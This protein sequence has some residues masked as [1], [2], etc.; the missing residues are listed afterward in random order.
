MSSETV[1]Q[2][3][4][5][6]PR[7]ETFNLNFLETI[8]QLTQS[9]LGNDPLTGQ[10][11]G[12]GVLLPP[13]Y[14]VA[15]TSGLENLGAL[16]TEAGIGS[17]MPY[18]DQANQALVNA[19]GT[20]GSSAIPY[21]EA[22]IG[23][24]LTGQDYTTEAYD[25]AGATRDR[26]Y[27]TI[28]QGLGS[29][30]GTDAMFDPSSIAPFM[31]PYETEVI[32]QMMGD[33]DRARQITGNQIGA[34]AA[35]AGAFGGAR[36]GL[37]EAENNRNA[38]E[39]MARNAANIRQSGYESAAGRAQ[40]AFEN[41]LGRGQ[42][43]GNLQANIGMGIGGLGQADVATLASLGSQY[44]SL[45]QGI[46]GLGQ[47]IGSLGGQLGQLGM[48]FA[49]LGELNTNLNRADID[50]A[51]QVGGL[52]RGVQQAG[53]DANRQNILNAQNAPYQYYGF[54][55]DVL[56]RVPSSQSTITQQSSAGP[57]PFQQVAGLGIAGLSTAQGINAVGGLF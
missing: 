11:T 16:L 6:D 15:N 13:E 36:H 27:G 46:G 8:R 30:V 17:Y 2:I 33:I 54:L 18:L 7:L 38:L 32:D 25:L 56:S 48:Q 26:P 53:L 57:S 49:G 34:D 12:Q 43:L 24:I 42:S 35:A 22:G 52:Q 41:A 1:T 21:M 5:Q 3:T 9:R 31:N 51:L 47:G 23:G 4:R 55:S 28:S 20:V 45:G 44:G 39:S 50:A 10:P 14:R 40:G 29:L 37:V 19:S